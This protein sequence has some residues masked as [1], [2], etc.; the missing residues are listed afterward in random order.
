VARVSIWFDQEGSLLD[1]MFAE[2]EGQAF[3]EPTADD[4]VM[5]IVDEAGKVIGFQIFPLSSVDS[6]DI[7][8]TGEV[9]PDA[10]MD[11]SATAVG[12]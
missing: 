8:L 12:R 7:E 3:H 6:L 11:P 2:P 5:Q 4:R 1:V 10:V 9:P